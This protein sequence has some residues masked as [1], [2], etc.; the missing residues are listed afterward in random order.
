[1]NVVELLGAN[2]RHFRKL[3]GMT[4]EQLAMLVGM[5][6]SYFSNVERGV[7]NPSVMVI[8]RLAHSLNIEPHVLLLSRLS[9]SK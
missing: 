7:R 4:Q 2:M 9:V 1:M 5:E 8:A 6:R 3:K